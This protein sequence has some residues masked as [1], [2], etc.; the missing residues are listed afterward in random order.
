MEYDGNFRTQMYEQKQLMPIGDL[1]DKYSTTYKEL[2]AKFPLLKKLGTREDGKLYDFGR[3]LGYVPYHYVVVRQ[4][5]LDKLHLQVPKTT[6]ELYQVAKAF[7]TQDPDGDGKKD[8]YG[9]NLSTTAPGDDSWVNY[10]FQNVDWVVQ[11]G[12]LM[13]DWDRA[14]AAAAFKKKLFDEGIVDKDFLTDKNGKKAEQDFVTGKT[15]VYGAAGNGLYTLYQ[16]LRKNVPNA[17]LVPIALP[18][19][20]FGQFTPDFNPPVQLT[21]VLN[22]KTKDPEAAIK[23]VDFLSS[24]D[25]VKTTY[26]GIEGTHY[27]M[28]GGKEVPIDPDKNKKELDWLGDYRMLG[29]QYVYD[30]FDTTMK[31]FDQSKPFDKEFYDLGKQ[32]FSLYITKDRPLARITLPGFFPDLPADMNFIAKNLMDSAGNPIKDL[33]SKAIVSGTSYSVS[34]AKQDAINLWK[35]SDGDKL[36]A[37]YQD[38]YTK[39]KDTMISQSDLI[40]MN[41]N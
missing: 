29:G 30:E 32:L 35:K 6:D 36:E 31:S 14:E 5:W 28:D 40:S 18:A 8:T 1:I 17:K 11:D 22:A 16:T 3:V 24:Q 15:G 9:L 23:M 10:M 38:W 26:S 20:Q 37:W 25:W 27:K 4:D 2:L 34:Q 7:A 21:G 19:S 33:W 13:K 41:F 39:N 12:K